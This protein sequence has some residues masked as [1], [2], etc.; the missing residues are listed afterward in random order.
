MESSPH[1]PMSLCN[2]RITEQSIQIPFLKSNLRPL[3]W[4]WKG[5]WCVEVEPLQP[6][7]ITAVGGLERVYQRNGNTPM[8]SCHNQ[9][10]SLCSRISHLGSSSVTQVKSEAS[11]VGVEG[12]IAAEPM[13]PMVMT[14]SYWGLGWDILMIWQH[15][16]DILSTSTHA[17][18]FLNHIS[19]CWSFGLPSQIWG[20]SFGLGIVC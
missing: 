16:R 18:L 10:M 15:S 5:V 6:M 12:R 9:S 17:I 1:H 2:T 13:Q 20:L 7:W 11:P 14:H 8:T 4:A 19:I 3:F